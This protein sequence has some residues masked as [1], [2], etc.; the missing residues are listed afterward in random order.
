MDVTIN[1]SGILL[2]QA[3]KG[4]AES[5]TVVHRLNKISFEASLEKKGVWLVNALHH[6]DVPRVLPDHVRA[7]PITELCHLMVFRNKT[8]LLL[9]QA[10]SLVGNHCEKGLLVEEL[11]NLLCLLVRKVS[12]LLM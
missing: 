5:L 2:N 4:H 9:Y 6:L 7:G 12:V 8:E 10:I 1:E 11:V 3:L